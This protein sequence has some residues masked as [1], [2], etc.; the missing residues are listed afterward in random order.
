MKIPTFFKTNN[1]P[2]LDLVINSNFISETAKNIDHGQIIKYEKWRKNV[3][4]TVFRDDIINHLIVKNNYL[5]Y[6]E[7]GVYDGNNFKKINIDH[8][9]GVDPTPQ[10]EG[11]PFTHFRLTSDN[12][13][14]HLS[15]NIYFDIIFIDGL[16]HGEQVYRDI[17]NSLEHLK[18]NGTV[19]LHDCNPRF[20]ILQRK[21]AVVGSW[22]G[23]C[24]KGFVQC[25]AEID[26][27]KAYVI[28]TDH[29]IGII[30]KGDKSEK[31]SNLKSAFDL[32]YNF[33]DRHRKTLLNLISVDEF[34]NLETL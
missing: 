4:W 28:D 16:H 5:H 34:F 1:N 3:N 31:L 2:I 9:L 30:K 32:T 8:K 27:I 7:I 14:I 19:V 12:F 33:F 6:L 29:G 22:N 10:A 13:F 26:N 20:E 24:W 17:K 21:Y 15:S 25:R 23:D 11:E 18:P